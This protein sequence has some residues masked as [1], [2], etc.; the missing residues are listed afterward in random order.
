VS[1]ITVVI[2]DD[3]AIVRDGLRLI[4]GAERDIEVVGEAKNIAGAIQL[5]QA[6]QPHVLLLDINLGDDSGLQALPQLRELRPET[7]ILVLTMQKEPLHARHA[8]DAGAAGYVLKDSAGQD[9]V[10]AIRTVAAG[11]TY[12]EPELGAE[13]LRRKVRQE[14]EPLTPRERE[15]IALLAL[16]HT[17][18]EIAENLVLSVR[19]VESHRARIHEKLGLTS[20]SEVV[21]YAIENGLVDR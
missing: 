3:H 17:N 18:A 1:R 19:T 5:L 12:L 11:G 20:R 4:L 10:R 2:A 21:R 8:L 14:A 13:L 15:V 7:A 9:L 16:G 6:E